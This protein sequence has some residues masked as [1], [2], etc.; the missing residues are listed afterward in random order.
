MQLPHRVGSISRVSQ[1]RTAVEQ[2]ES[3]VLTERPNPTAD[4]QVR[5]AT[6]FPRLRGRVK[7]QQSGVK[8]TKPSVHRTGEDRAPELG[9]FTNPCASETAAT[10][11]GGAVAGGI[12]G[13]YAASRRA[14]RE[15][16]RERRLSAC[17]SSSRAR[18]ELSPRRLPTSLSVCGGSPPVPK[19]RWMTVRS[20]S[21]SVSIAF[22]TAS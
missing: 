12:R 20:L 1:A 11:L 6:P 2:A 17:S 13:G 19:R 4:V 15:L 9:V 8:M 18:V 21:G 16:S 3:P 14:A 10:A 7:T 5:L 22:C